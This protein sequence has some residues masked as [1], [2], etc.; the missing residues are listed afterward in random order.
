MKPRA[1]IETTVV[2]YLTG[3]T[4]RNLII[5]AHQELTRE[6][7]DEVLPVLGGCISDLVLEEASDG[8]ATAAAKRLEA[9][10]SIPVLLPGKA[11]I[12]ITEAIMD[13][14]L[15]P[16][17]YVNDAVHV[18]IAAANGIE[19]LVTWNC[20]HLANAWIRTRLVSL[21]ESLGYRCPVIC[22]PEELM[23]APQ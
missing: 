15:V 12:E 22:T 8:D 11:S 21:I 6:W 16:D 18:A 7:W 13:S 17:A 14:G 23:E 4:G 3:R 10:Q 19:F 5:A 9:L 1:Y 2:S 20:K